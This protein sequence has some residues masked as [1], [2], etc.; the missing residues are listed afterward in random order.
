MSKKKTNVAAQTPLSKIKVVILA[1]GY[2]SRISAETGTK[3]KPMVEIGQHPIIWHIMK[4]YSHYGLNDFII[5]AG[6]K[7]DII[8]KY[9]ANYY[10]ENFN[11]TYDFANNKMDYH[12]NKKIPWKV[13]VVDT[14]QDT[15]TG[16]RVKRVQD[17]IGD[18]TFCLTYGDG[19][20]DIKIDE[21]I[22]YHYQQK[23]IATVTA[24][25]PPQH[26]G[27]ITLSEDKQKVKKFIEKP[28]ENGVWVNGGFFVLEPKVFDYLKNDKTIWETTPLRK[29][30]TQ[31]QLA[32]HKHIGHWHAMDTLQDKQKLEELWEG[33]KAPWKVW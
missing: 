29:I 5:C 21:L 3:P 24:V 18:N 27:V 33:D 1:G 28:K 8:K 30:T 9:F 20:G 2:G 15:M 4:I 25:R 32:A 11:F 26:L 31:G 7:G 12:A 13:T 17:L 23:T 6:Y 16:G 14:G 19:V 10:L 22:K